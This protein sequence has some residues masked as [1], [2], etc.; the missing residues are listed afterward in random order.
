MA[1]QRHD[2]L[3]STLIERV[4]TA[5]RAPNAPCKASTSDSQL[6]VNLVWLESEDISGIALEE[7]CLGGTARAVLANR[8]TLAN[9]AGMDKIILSSAC[10]V[11]ITAIFHPDA[12]RASRF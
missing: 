5:Y 7:S 4:P 1:R 10:W 8:V 2:A 11:F 6:G 12:I 3:L 9:K